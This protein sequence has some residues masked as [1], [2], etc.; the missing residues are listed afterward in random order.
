MSETETPILLR[1]LPPLHRERLVIPILPGPNHVDVGVNSR[2][3]HASEVAPTRD[4]AIAV[5]VASGGGEIVAEGAR[6][7]E[8][9]DRRVQGGKGAR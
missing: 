4:L 6:D 2:L 1:R 3:G 7:G 9:R 5:V 8:A